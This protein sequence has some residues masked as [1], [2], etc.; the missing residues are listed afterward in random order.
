[1]SNKADK[2]DS[3][4]KQQKPQR[5]TRQQSV[6]NVASGSANVANSS[7]IGDA[8]GATANWPTDVDALAAVISRKVAEMMDDKLAALSSKL[9]AYVAKHDQDAER[10][11]EAEGRISTVEDVTANLEVRLLEAE[12][13]VAT[14]TQRLDDQIARSRRDNIRI[15]GV[16]SGVEGKNAVAFFE[17]WLPQVLNMEAKNGR[18]RLD[19]CHR[20]LGQ[21]RPNS[22]R[23]VVMKLHHSD[24]KMRIMTAYNKVK[25]KLEYKGA[26]I[27][28]RQDLPYNIVQQ[29]RSFNAICEH[30][31]AKKLKFKMRF[32]STLC[33]KYNNKDFAFDNAMEAKD[34][35]ES[36]EMLQGDAAS[37]HGEDHQ[38]TEDQGPDQG[39]DEDQGPDRGSDDHTT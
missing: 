34:M 10:L 13:N 18:I 9:D 38:R 2:V 28:I 6:A 19:R 27:T 21:P 31:I 8:S 7:E 39:S 16:K 37:D 11:T 14:L 25:S 22:P 36:L 12:A 33:F 30:L 23:V 17:T 24:D 15:F 3:A 35:L 20:G 26:K 1:M 32:P 29:R 4:D 5:V